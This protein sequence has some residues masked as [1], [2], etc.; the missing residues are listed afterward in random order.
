M[1]I[2]KVFMEA[3]K[4]PRQLRSFATNFYFSGSNCFQSRF[5]FQFFISSLSCAVE[6]IVVVVVVDVV[7]VIV[8][9]DVDVVRLASL[10]IPG[11]SR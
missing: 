6:V 3:G 8:A 10:D 4:L 9:I 11:C 2:V 1:A 5:Y 7:V